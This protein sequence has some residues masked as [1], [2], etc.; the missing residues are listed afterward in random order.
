M[1]RVV[2]AEVGGHQHLQCQPSGSSE[3]PGLS[4][5]ILGVAAKSPYLACSER[6][7]LARYGPEHDRTPLRRMRKVPVRSA[8]AVADQASY[9]VSGT[10]ARGRAY[11]R[12]LRRGP[13]EGPGTGRTSH[14]HPQVLAAPTQAPL[15]DDPNHQ[16]CPSRP[17]PPSDQLRLRTEKA[18][19]PASWDA[20][21][22]SESIVRRVS[23][24]AGMGAGHSVRWIMRDALRGPWRRSSSWLGRRRSRSS[25]GVWP[26]GP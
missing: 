24:L 1:L 3:L 18:Q 17:H 22:A 23:L 8:A 10:A 12:G 25:A 21:G 5:I 16:P 15:L 4:K 19:W 6:R 9:V 14:R 7:S 13:R 20:S 26:G 11:H 2:F